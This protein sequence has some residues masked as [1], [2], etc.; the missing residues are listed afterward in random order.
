MRLGEPKSASECLWGR[1]RHGQKP[2]EKIEEEEAA[3]E[4]REQR[5]SGEGES[6]GRDAAWSAEE[7]ACEGRPSKVRRK[8]AQS[9]MD[10]LVASRLQLQLQHGSQASSAAA[11]PSTPSYQGS[12]FLSQPIL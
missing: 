12:S 10:F 6:G 3:G 2:F 8:A 4:V 5:G 7:G 9:V 1:E 11:A